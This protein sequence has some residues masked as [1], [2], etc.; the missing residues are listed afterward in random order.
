MGFTDALFIVVSHWYIILFVSL[1]LSAILFGWRNTDIIGRIE[2][3]TLSEYMAALHRRDAID[4]LFTYLCMVAAYPYWYIFDHWRGHLLPNYDGPNQTFDPEEMLKTLRFEL[5][6]VRKNIPDGVLDAFVGLAREM[7]ALDLSPGTEEQHRAAIENPPNVFLLN[8]FNDFIT[9]FASSLLERPSH[10]K[11]HLYSVVDEK[12]ISALFWNIARNDIFKASYMG[13]IKR[14]A[15]AEELIKIDRM[16]RGSRRHLDFIVGSKAFDTFLDVTVPESARFEGTWIVAPQGRGKTTLLS[17]L[18][19][20]DLDS[21]A[22]GEASVIIFDSKGD[23]S[24]HVRKLKSFAPGEDLAGK[25]TLIEPSGSLALNPLDLG[26]STTHNIALLEYVFASLLDSKMTPL[27]STLFR[28]IVMAMKAIPGANFG[29]FRKFLQEGWKPFEQYILTLHPD[30]RDFF[31][32]PGAG[33][34]TEWDSKDYKDRKGE[35]LW[36]VRDLTTRVPLIREMFQ[37]PATKIDMGKEM[38]AGNVIIIDNSTAI[39]SESGSEF[40]SRFFIA[41]ILAAAQQ[42]AGRTQE[43][44]KPVYVYLDEA[45]TVIANDDKVA[46]I[47]QQCRSQKIAMI[48]AHQELQQIKSEDVRSALAN[49]AVRIANPDKDA[50][51]LASDF[52]TD[53]EYLQSLERGEFALFIR[54]HTKKALTIRADNVPVSGWPKMT[55]EQFQAIREEMRER[56]SF[57]PTPAAE[58]V[59]EEEDDARPT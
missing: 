41:L 43:N 37:A 36:R 33:G 35:L 1:V 34:V 12:M 7:V 44:K 9:R 57:T 30:D 47:I 56:Y 59:S 8:G 14:F 53:A 28:S 5:K 50:K 51:A 6:A 39:L 40:F 22:D 11:T 45:H 32:K 55:E 25:L 31:L 15:D 38:D 4:G 46:T 23:L 54:D 58:P 16:V 26:A 29:T 48:F 20:N 17:C 21:V 42:R 13:F 19:S 52:R 2:G 10:L 49:C 27:Q 24:D 18:L 3:N